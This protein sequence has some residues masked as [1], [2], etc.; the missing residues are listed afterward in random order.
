MTPPIPGSD[1]RPCWPEEQV[2]VAWPDVEH[3][4]GGVDAVADRLRAG[5]LTDKADVDGFIAFSLTVQNR[6]KSRAGKSLEH[7]GVLSR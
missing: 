3:D 7:Q 5:F 2:R 6:R 4:V 1:R